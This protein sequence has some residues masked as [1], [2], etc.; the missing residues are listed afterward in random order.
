LLDQF[1]ASP[2]DRTHVLFVSASRRVLRQ[3]SH[4]FP[5]ATLNEVAGKSLDHVTVLVILSADVDQDSETTEASIV[6]SS[7]KNLR[8][9]I[10]E[11]DSTI[12]A[13]EN[14]LFD[15]F[16][17]LG[18]FEVRC[19][20]S[21]GFGGSTLSLARSLIGGAEQGKHSTIQLVTPS[22]AN[23]GLATNL[24]MVVDA[25][26][27]EYSVAFA[28]Y[29]LLLG[30]PSDQFQIIAFDEETLAQVADVMRSRALRIDQQN[31]VSL[32]T[33]GHQRA[34]AIYATTDAI[35]RRLPRKDLLLAL[36][37]AREGHYFICQNPVAVLSESG[38]LEAFGKLKIALGEVFPTNRSMEDEGRVY[39]V[40]SFA[41]L[42]AIVEQLRQGKS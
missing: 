1:V 15:R 30:Y 33:A 4:A 36:T 31:L 34:I 7:M 16:V 38:V 20:R 26:A 39:T 25:N 17:R 24:Q 9:L 35:V 40:E 29:L 19:G 10:L 42:Q 18:A 11:G 23:T 12:L 8:K 41:H 6:I 2:A 14:C 27:V 28:E 5:T 3:F 32:H 21:C 22:T 37:C 13:V